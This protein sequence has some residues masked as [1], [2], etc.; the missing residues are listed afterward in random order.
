MNLAAT[1]PQIIRPVVAQRSAT[2]SSNMIQPQPYRFGYMAF[3][4]Y[5]VWR[6]VSESL[7]S[8]KEPSDPVR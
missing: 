5:S 6:R 2:E 7:D 3:G 8:F 4:G 1:I